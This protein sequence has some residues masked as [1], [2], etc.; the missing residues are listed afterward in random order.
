MKPEARTSGLLLREL[1]GELLVYDEQTHTAHCL[2]RTA[3]VVFRACDGTRTVDE[4][5]SLIDPAPSPE[6]R[7]A[8]ELAL[9]QIRA[10]GLLTAD[11]APP[12]VQPAPDGG[13]TRRDAARRVGF[14][15]AILLPAVA[16]MVAPTPAEAA[17]TCVSSCVGQPNGT[18]CDV[19]TTGAFCSTTVETCVSGTCSDGCPG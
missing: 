13:L 19:C 16:T 1:P 5:A 3:A 17:A 8:V 10:A 9:A 18:R 11:G 6:A 7:E 14:A 12:L 2:N 15:A 4:I